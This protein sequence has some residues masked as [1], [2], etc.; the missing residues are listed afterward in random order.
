MV[1]RPDLAR[2]EIELLNTGL[3]PFVLPRLRDGHSSFRHFY[4]DR[5]DSFGPASGV[6]ARSGVVDRLCQ[7]AARPS[8]FVTIGLIH[9]D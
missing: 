5:F 7:S 4:F 8:Y 1:H 3:T 6:R 2:K 9:F